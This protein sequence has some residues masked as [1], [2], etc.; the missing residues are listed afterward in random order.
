[1][2]TNG[3]KLLTLFAS[4]ATLL[5]AACSSNLEKEVLLLPAKDFAKFLIESNAQLLDVRSESEYRKKHLGDA[6][7]IDINKQRFDLTAE[8]FLS[9]ERPVAI[10]CLHGDRSSIAADILSDMG[11]TVVELQDGIVDWEERIEEQ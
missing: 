1:M 4:F 10:Y 6:I 7:N 9:R 8:Q 2:K 3:K 5:L 11:Y